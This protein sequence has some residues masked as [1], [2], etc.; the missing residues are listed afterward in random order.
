MHQ[1]VGKKA[2]LMHQK[3]FEE[4]VVTVTEQ[5]GTGSIHILKM[6]T[7]QNQ[8]QHEGHNQ[9]QREKKSVAQMDMPIDL[10]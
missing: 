5:T 4:H 7:D 9:N 2:T 10:K 1:E 6:S 8:L 3:L